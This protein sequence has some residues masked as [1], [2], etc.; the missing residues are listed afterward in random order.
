MPRSSSSKRPKT[1]SSPKKNPSPRASTSAL[2]IIPSLP[3]KH[4]KLLLALLTLTLYFQVKD[5]K[6]LS[7][8]D[9]E[10]VQYNHRLQPP[11]LETLRF[12][13]TPV[14][15]KEFKQYQDIYIPMTY[16]VWSALALLSDLFFPGTAYT[17]I[18]P[19]VFHLANLAI[20]ILTALT[21]H[22]ILLILLAK[23][24]NGNL[25]PPTLRWLA[26]LGASFYAIHPVQVEAVCWISGMKDLLCALFCYL[27]TLHWLRF[28]EAQPYPH[29]RA[30]YY[31]LTLLAFLLASTSKPQAIN[32]PL[33]L[34][35]LSL[36]IY[37]IPIR[38]LLLPILPFLLIATLTAIL[39]KLLQPDKVIGTLTPLWTRPF[40]AL[41]AFAFY[42]YKILLPI[43]LCFDYSRTPKHI[44]QSGQI[45]YTWLLP[46]AITIAALLSPHR[47]LLLSLIALFLAGFASVS[48]IIP[49][50]SQ[51]VSTTSDRYLL[52]P[53]LAISLAAPLLVAFL[54]QKFS[55]HVSL[56]RNLSILILLGLIPLTYHQI[57]TWR[58]DVTFYG[59][60]SK[61]NPLSYRALNNLALNYYDRGQLA[62]AE[63]L[64]QQCAQINHTDPLTFSN[65]GLV[66]MKLKKYNDAR[67]SLLRAIEL[68]RHAHFAYSHLGMLETELGNHPEAMAWFQ[69][70]LDEAPNTFAY[71]YNLANAALKA[72]R[73]DIAFQALQT[74][75]RLHPDHTS[76]LNDLGALLIKQ[77]RLSEALPYIQKAI[78][79]DTQANPGFIQNWFTLHQRLGIQPDPSQPPYQL[80]LADQAA[81]N[82]D[83]H[84]AIAILSDL[85]ARHPHTLSAYH[86]LSQL[87]QAIG[88]PLQAQQTLLAAL[89]Q[90][91]L[92]GYREIVYTLES[93]LIRRGLPIR[94]TVI[95]DD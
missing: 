36:G 54:T 1:T 72:G 51:N 3:L 41:D 84:R 31:A 42:L 63:E 8:D 28:L 35:V 68:R 58:D 86:R 62:K 44:L 10:T 49:F 2:Q 83:P 82:N 90:A 16:T 70:A 23:I 91:R 32:L 20:H 55:Q 27:S 79:I 78:D 48:G 7:W 93:L 87:Q 19:A 14:V 92:L 29:Q 9:Q 66:Q 53:M 67:V 50:Y 45:Y 43:N 65:L 46:V 17:V 12:Y 60:T 18:H 21:V 4:P 64:F 24:L 30:K 39:A 38:S 13:W 25:A 69:K 76:S 15:P 40:I 73:E 52:L 75:I 88:Q 71:A 95:Q 94:R 74:C 89:H 47:R 6:F 81:K 56:I 57:T 26:L 80:H 33:I 59:H 34:I 5:F 77:N 37:R 61:I 85:I 22:A 11:T